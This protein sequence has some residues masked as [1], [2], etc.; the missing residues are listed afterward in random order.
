[1][2]DLSLV[3]RNNPLFEKDVADVEYNLRAKIQGSSF[4][5]LGAA[6]TIGQATAI[7]LF[8]RG[9]KRLHVVDISENN[10]VELVRKIRSSVG[11]GKGD[12][13]TYCCDIGSKEFN[14][15]IS[16]H[17]PYD[18]IFNLAAMKHVRSERDP[19]T[20]MRLIRTNILDTVNTIEIASHTNA[21]KYFCVSTD[22]AANPVNLMG[23][24]KRIMELFAAQHS[25][26][27]SISMS[28][29]ANVAFSDGS[30]LHGF[31]QR[32]L[33]KQPFSA[34]NDVRRYFVTQKEAG[35]LC[36]L[37]GI[38]GHNR[39]IFFPKLNAELH[40]QQ[41][42]A[43]AKNYLLSRGFEPYECSTE[44]EAR[45]EFDKLYQS[46]RWPCFFFKSDT[47][48]EKPFE[49]FYTSNELLDLERYQEVGVIQSINKYD[50]VALARFRSDIT[51]ML[52]RGYWEKTEIVDAIRSVLPSLEYTDTGKYLDEK[53]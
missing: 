13:K 12:F 46:K 28:R 10:L 25:D 38:L 17:A 40:L 33:N 34:P 31:H 4:L 5:V 14:L 51:S 18:Y 29:F 37:S 50:P 48:G 24:S 7:E 44:D 9:P 32:F 6:G 53:M 27:I 42:T 41:F 3:G 49:E 45:E 19:I 47:T 15:L 26:T 30:L 20:L 16:K 22:K 21:N 2:D 11:Y 52:D 35:L 43:I 23:A 8:K 39:E 1:M 36:L